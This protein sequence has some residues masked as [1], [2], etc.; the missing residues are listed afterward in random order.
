MVQPWTNKGAT[1]HKRHWAVSR[2]HLAILP[3]KGVLRPTLSQLVE[4]L[5]LNNTRKIWKGPTTISGHNNNSGRN[6]VTGVREWANKLNL[7]F[8]RFVS[9]HSPSP[10][11]QS[12]DQTLY[13]HWTSPTP[14]PPTRHPDHQHCPPH[15]ILFSNPLLN[16]DHHQPPSAVACFFFTFKMLSTQYNHHC[17]G[18][19]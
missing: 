11:H 19:S 3:A 17:W 2:R 8:Y 12:I 7:F 16:R 10:T 6:S 4:R 1:L 18:G 9:A 14:S 13:G 5:Q 15:A